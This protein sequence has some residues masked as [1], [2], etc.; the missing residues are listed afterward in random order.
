M[1]I[2][3]III[4]IVVVVVALIVIIKIKILIFDHYRPN[5][6]FILHSKLQY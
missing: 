1:S 3:L 2:G 5:N 6:D 4:I